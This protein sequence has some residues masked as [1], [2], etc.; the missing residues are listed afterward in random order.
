MKSLFRVKNCRLTLLR[1]IDWGGMRSLTSCNYFREL[2]SGECGS[3]VVRIDSQK[4]SMGYEGKLNVNKSDNIPC[5]EY[6][7]MSI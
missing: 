2:T 3:I 4:I 7:H 1:P 5:S 6:V